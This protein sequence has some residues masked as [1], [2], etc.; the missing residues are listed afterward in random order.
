MSF[1]S[2]KNEEISQEKKT[3][4]KKVTSLPFFPLL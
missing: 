2:F 1:P 3:E 4:R